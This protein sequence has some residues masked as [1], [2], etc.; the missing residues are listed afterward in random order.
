VKYRYSI[1]SNGVPRVTDERVRVAYDC[2]LAIETMARNEPLEQSRNFL[3]NRTLRT[4]RDENDKHY[5]IAMH[6]RRLEAVLWL[7]ALTY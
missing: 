4:L 2:E 1:D 7:G 5:G 6:L 3:L